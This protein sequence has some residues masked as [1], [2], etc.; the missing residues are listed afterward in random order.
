MA[1]SGWAAMLAFSLLL[2]PPGGRSLNAQ[3]EITRSVLDM[4]GGVRSS[5]S[6]TLVDAAGQTAVGVSSSSHYILAAGFL[7]FGFGTPPGIEEPEGEA[8][9]P[10]V[11]SLS[12]NYPNP[13]NPRTVIRIEIPGREGEEV[14]VRLE[15][16]NLRGQRIRTLVDGSRSPGA[17]VVSWDGRDEH[18]EHAGSG[19][20]LYRLTAGEFTATKKMV[21]V[22]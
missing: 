19:V 21:M 17:H 13:F 22:Q 20:Y 14:P 6:Y 16:F 1:I 8:L 11:Y 9:L 5:S 4:G 10:R 12:Q 7:A 18:G 15:V 2:Y 3:Y